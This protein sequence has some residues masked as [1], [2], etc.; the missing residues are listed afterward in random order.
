[1]AQRVGSRAPF[2][3]PFDR[4]GPAGAAA[5]SAGGAVGAAGPADRRSAD[6]APRPRARGRPRGR[7]SAAGEVQLGARALVR[8]DAVPARPEQPGDDR[9]LAA[10]A[11][12]SAGRGRAPRS[13]PSRTGRSARRSAARSAPSRPG[14]ARSGRPGPLTVP[15]GIWAKTAAVARGPP[16]PTRRADRRRC[17]RARRAAARRRRWTSASRQRVVNVD[18]ALP[19]NQTRGSDGQGVDH[20]ERV[21]PAAVRRADE[22]V[23]AAGR[24]SWPE[25]SIRNRNATE[26]DEPGEEPEQRGTRIDARASGVRPSHARPS[27]APPRASARAC[28]RQPPRRRPGGRRGRAGGSGSWRHLSRVARAGSSASS[29]GGPRL[30]GSPASASSGPR[31]RRGRRPRRRRP[32]R[33]RRRRRRLV[34]PSASSP[35]VLP[36]RVLVVLGRRAT[37]GPAAGRPRS[38]R[39]ARPV[40]VPQ[41]DQAD[42]DEAERSRAGPSGSRRTSSCPGA[43]SR[44]RTA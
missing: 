23:A 24:C 4:A 41:P 8:D 25:V 14:T 34:A 18:G 9:R 31:R 19:R 7:R 12:P 13:R 30:A 2:R 32:R 1:M 36:E 28:G 33:R 17:R 21:H 37:T 3:R 22:Q 43:G 29:P 40:A 35:R 20:E 39:P 11:T 15:S 10:P 16:A 6:G 5:T 27:T 42:E 38:R 26:Q 44:G